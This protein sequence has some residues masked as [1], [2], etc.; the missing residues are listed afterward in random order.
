M[1]AL[2]AAIKP[3]PYGRGLRDLITIFL[4]WKLL[5]L[6]IACASPG[7]GYDTSTQILLDQHASGDETWLA[8][9]LER[10]ILRLTR[11]DGIYFASASTHGHV[12]EQEWAFSWV[13]AKVTSGV[14]RV[15]FSPASFSPLVKHALAGVLISHV[16]HLLAVTVLYRLALNVVPGTDATRR[17]VA[18]IASCLHI[19]SPAGIFLSAPYGESTFAFLN[20]AG[21]LS[22]ILAV[23]QRH[24]NSHRST[25]NGISYVLAAGAFF[26]AAATI[27]SNGLLSGLI[28]AWDAIEAF[29][30]PLNTMR[31]ARS[32]ARFSATI[33]A[34]MLVAVGFAA[35]Q[36]VAYTEYCT[37]G[38]TR[39]WCSHIPPSIYTWVQGHYWG[40]GFLRYWT[41]NNLPLFL[42]AGPV[43]GLLLV[44]GLMALRWPERTALA[45]TQQQGRN[46]K[47][48]DTE[49]VKHVLPRF[50]LPQLVLAL[51][52]AT[53]F[54]VQIINRISSG[55]PSCY[56]VLAIAIHSALQPSRGGDS[57][58]R[59]NMSQVPVGTESL[60]PLN[61]WDEKHCRWIVRG[62]VMYALVQGGLYASFLPPA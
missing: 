1:S 56:I 31:D 59:D 43:L 38:N 36:V 14:A 51:M 48:M 37:G 58:A 61:I 23:R 60:W 3:T 10:V 17:H 18:F 12:N 47:V 15:V 45:P 16:S 33:L 27:R 32:M 34:G 20:F 54:H 21:M 9:L 35:P 8:R 29:I 11:W 28:F 62:M 42:L 50:A 40:V 6:A 44:T 30:R 26:G 4:G 19:I 52:A 55:Y 39:P 24:S 57:G 46:M 2:G 49:V 41:L 53:S 13:L 5:L 7:P 22:Y 25:S